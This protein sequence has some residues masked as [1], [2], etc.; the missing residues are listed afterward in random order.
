MDEGIKEQKGERKK[1]DNVKRK[2][3]K[4]RK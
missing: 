2:E 4:R 3:A 1:R